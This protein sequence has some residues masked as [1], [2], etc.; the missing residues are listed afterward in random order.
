MPY[1]E[2]H[3]RLAIFHQPC[4]ILSNRRESGGRERLEEKIPTNS[5]EKSDGSPA[6]QERDQNSAHH[7]SANRKVKRLVSSSTAT[8]MLVLSNCG[9]PCMM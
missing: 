3:A 1:G 4:P 7:V 5:L 8:I 2:S 6:E 9:S